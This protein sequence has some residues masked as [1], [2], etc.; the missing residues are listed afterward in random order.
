MHVKKGRTELLIKEPI[1]EMND[2]LIRPGNGNGMSLTLTPRQTD[3]PGRISP[4]LSPTA[5][6]DIEFGDILR[7][8]HPGNRY[9]MILASGAEDGGKRATLALSMA[10][11]ALSMDLSTLLFLAGNGSYWAYQGHADGIR[12]DGFPSLDELLQSF[13]DLGGNLSVCSTSNQAMCHTSGSHDKAWALR[14]EV[15]VQSMA[16]VMEHL[17]QGRAVTF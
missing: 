1:M 3:A 12:I 4:V 15:Q 14:P 17:L 2:V 16:T 8:G 10:C 7:V 13:V 9:T 6:I 11:T 5:D